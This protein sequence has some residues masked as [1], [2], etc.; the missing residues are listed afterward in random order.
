MH[1]ILWN[2]KKGIVYLDSE[3]HKA[4]QDGLHIASAHFLLYVFKKQTRL[5]VSLIQNALTKYTNV[6]LQIIWF[7]QARVILEP[8]SNLL[9]IF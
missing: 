8:I 3:L 4:I 6:F 7:M 2:S 9:L 5:L 1:D